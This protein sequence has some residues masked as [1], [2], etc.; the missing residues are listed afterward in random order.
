MDEMEWVG[1]RNRK[2][3]GVSGQIWV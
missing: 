1:S 3:W 2:A